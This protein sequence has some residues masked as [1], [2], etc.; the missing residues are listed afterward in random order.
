MTEQIETMRRLADWISNGEW[1]VYYNQKNDDGYDKFH[2]PSSKPDLLLKKNGYNVLVEVKPGD[3]HQH[4]LD[5]YGQ[6]LKYAGQY[7]TGRATNYRRN[8]KDENLDIDAFVLATSYSRD[9]HL[10]QKEQNTGTVNYSGFLAKEKGMDE[11]PITHSI[12]R[13]MWRQWEKGKHND[14]YRQLRRS[15]N[16]SVKMRKKPKVGGIVSKIDYETKQST[17]RPYFYLNSN[18]FEPLRKQKVKAFR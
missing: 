13:L 16:N 4:L 5:G 15:S 14:Y 18:Q 10:Y 7:W 11:Y 9:G 8:G 6:T 12:L 17:S 3:E 1:T 2:G